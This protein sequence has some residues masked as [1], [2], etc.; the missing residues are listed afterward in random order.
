MRKEFG[1][2]AKANANANPI[3]ILGTA[4]KYCA[5][6]ATK[7]VETRQITTRT[8]NK[9]ESI[10]HIKKLTKG[11]PM[12][13]HLTAAKTTHAHANENGRNQSPIHGPVSRSSTIS[14]NST[15][16]NRCRPAFATG[17]THS[18]AN[19]SGLAGDYAAL[20]TVPRAGCQSASRW[21]TRDGGYRRVRLQNRAGH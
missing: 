21:S 11:L 16:T 1:R 5:Q 8:R 4:C 9:R 3:G 13:K 19:K 14:R 15:V 6:G 20:S 18:A 2:H 17:W 7:G 10:K 12:Q